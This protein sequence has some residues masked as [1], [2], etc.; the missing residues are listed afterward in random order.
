MSD[1]AKEQASGLIQHF[2]DA[3]AA[4]LSQISGTALQ[5]RPVEQDTAVKAATLIRIEI[6]GALEGICELALSAPMTAEF[7]AMLMGETADLSR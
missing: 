5:A 4:V 3:T 7:A 6:S 1:I 2:A